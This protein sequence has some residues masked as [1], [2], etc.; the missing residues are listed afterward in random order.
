MALMTAG[1]EQQ[2]SRQETVHTVMGEPLDLLIRLYEGAISFLEDAVTACEN[3]RIDGFKNGLHRATLIITELR[4]TLNH[5]EGGQVPK[6]LDDLYAFMLDSLGQAKLT[7]DVNHV[8]Q[9]VPH[10]K[11]LL[12]AWTDVRSMYHQA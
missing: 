4:K 7:H 9:V 2:H 12:D 10:L 11:T 8:H 1:A 6:Q 3:D 5:E